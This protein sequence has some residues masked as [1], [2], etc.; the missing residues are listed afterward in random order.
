LKSDELDARLQRPK[1]LI[2]A[3]ACTGC[4]VCAQICPRVAITFRPVEMSEA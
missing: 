4:E 3:T 1:A 2:D